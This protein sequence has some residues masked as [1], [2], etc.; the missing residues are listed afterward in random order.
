MAH[1]VLPGGR[2]RHRFRHGVVGPVPRDP[3]PHPGAP[4]SRAS[5][6]S[7]L[8]WA[9]V[10]RLLGFRQ[11][12][13]ASIGQ[14]GGNSTLVFFLTWFPTY[15]TRERHMD[16]IR[17]GFFAVLPYF[18]AGCGVLVGGWLSDRMLQQGRSLNFARKLPVIV[19]LLVHRPDSSL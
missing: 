2:H 5:P 11:V 6:Q 15:L 7:T 17:P 18:A 4:A 9:G 10:R 1:P 12:W 16:W 8:S 14:F 19:G 13:G 3:H